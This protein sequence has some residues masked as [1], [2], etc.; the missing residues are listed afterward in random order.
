ME[1]WEL[2]NRGN[3]LLS[4]LYV[5]A[6]IIFFTI[7][8]TIF[9]MILLLLGIIVFLFFS[10]ILFFHALGGQSKKG[11]T[12]MFMSYEVKFYIEPDA[13]NFIKK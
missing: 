7:F 11:T 5:I 2:G 4:S 3:S 9:F 1:T 13:R 10:H 12:V 8:F 6:Q